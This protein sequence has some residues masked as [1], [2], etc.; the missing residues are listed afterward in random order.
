M[1]RLKELAGFKTDLD[2]LSHED[3]ILARWGETRES[4]PLPEESSAPSAAA[5]PARSPAATAKPQPKAAAG[6]SARPSASAAPKTTPKPAPKE[7]PEEGMPPDFETLLSQMP[8]AADETMAELATARSQAP[9]EGEGIEELG[10]LD[11]ESLLGE[12]LQPPAAEA[13][14]G[15]LVD[16]G[17]KK[18]K[19]LPGFEAEEEPAG[20]AELGGFELGALDL[21]GEEEAHEAPAGNAAFGGLD[22]IEGAGLADGLA[23][24]G[25]LD[26]PS[27]GEV[28]GRE[29]AEPPLSFSLDELAS[30]EAEALP[31]E[32]A[33]LVDEDKAGGAEAFS[34]A[35]FGD[36]E[37]GTPAG[38]N[39]PAEASGG[40]SEES[41][42]IPDFGGESFELPGE[43][44]PEA[45]S[46]EELPGEGLQ[47]EPGSEA[48]EAPGEFSIPDLGEFSLGEEES[49]AS[50]ATGGSA[51]TEAPAEDFGFSIPDEGGFS[52]P[53]G[54]E[55]TAAEAGIG[56]DAFDSFSL[57][58]G[59]FDSAV[60]GGTDL[61]SQLAALGKGETQEA[62]TFSLDKDW[63]AGFE[64]PGEEAPAP[65]KTAAARTGAGGGKA[66]GGQ[67]PR[68]SKEE[69][70]R[71][72]SLSEDQVDRLQDRLLSFPLNLRLAV[73]DAIANELGTEAQR[74]KLVWMLVERK[75]F[76]EVATLVS[77]IVK[78]RVTVP[79]GYEKSTGADFVAEKG[80]FK[81][82][83]VHTV[84]PILRT[85][86]LALV[87]LGLLVFLGYKF[88]YRPLEADALYRSGYSHIGQDRYREAE[89]EFARAG[90]IQEYVSWYYR[91]AE[92]YAGKRQYLLAEKKYSDLLA[93][94]PDELKGA[95]A[96]AVLEKD[97]LK[98]KEG[99]DILKKRVLDS[100]YHDKDA[101][102][103]LGDIYL[104]WAGEDA[105]RYEDARMSYAT[106]I[107][108]YGMEDLYLSRMLL[109]F[110]RTDKL[111][112]VL[113]LK[114]HF[115]ADEKK[116]SLDAPA[117]AELGGYLFDKGMLEEVRTV[118]LAAVK[119]DGLN[120]EAHYNLARYFH[121]AESPQDER[122]ALDNAIASLKALTL[123]S[124][125]REAMLIDSLLRRG[126]LELS[127]RAYIAAEGDYSAAATEY[128]K[129]L[130]LGR[131][132]KSADFAAAY[133]G[134][135]EV[136]Y[137][138]R[139]DLA[140]ALT[141]F[142]RAAA[143]GY[144]KPGLRYQ[145]GYILYGQG[146]SK[147]AL[148]QLYTAGKGG[149]SPYLDFAFGDA[150]YARQD[151]QAAAA[152]Y[153]AVIKSMD[154]ALADLALPSPSEKASHA[155]IMELLM[156][157]QNNLGACL[158]KTGNRMGNA[159]LRAEAIAAFTESARLYDSLV[160]DQAQL[161][162]TSGENLGLANMNLL[163]S[164]TRNAEPRLY[165]R[166]ERG[167]A[168]PRQ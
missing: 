16:L 168:F 61:D 151:Y 81:Y 19:P 66:G 93:L 65:K 130:V 122:A 82:A 68:E 87:A 152:N 134:L 46:S 142:E 17:G 77:R 51:S 67:A 75:P 54:D 114:T 133:A 96:W 3:E 162:R 112:E 102:L 52:M 4:P 105:A 158:Y 90:K 89:D 153:R 164:A 129:A 85:A 60:F 26:F 34:L 138:Q 21:G 104:E 167:M 128:D 83:F 23:E 109:Y 115:L 9:D 116:I 143:D 127:E 79:T 159:R 80:S 24:L 63:G 166:L 106:L 154:K 131:V 155:E 41:F 95:L 1:P 13:A 11:L 110:I 107:Q 36:L 137:W 94:H 163:L 48:G 117:L 124:A 58:G 44:L 99:A 92:A 84:L 97:Q 35:D 49:P 47:S 20:T 70:A 108:N 121:K 119:K 136:A 32:G 140:A 10:D 15:G 5:A 62:E 71:E 72:V 157:A 42:A 22:G 123:V 146:R 147:D 120:P 100:H 118:L 31:E 6:P 150:L 165:D 132:R 91:Y 74:A 7:E 144:D 30:T 50:S 56:G 8:L 33:A 38:E 103:L 98:Y 39:A 40:I 101:L 55:G 78:R 12:P 2:A 27:P 57:D 135:G 160:R 28:A 88:I 145:R 37:S 64:M 53:A 25:S 125:K 45:A 18:A 43:S 29:G 148:E 111:K 139:G 113:P 14:G 149:A 86:A 76:D 161:L 126:D 141:W 69:K 156:E 73:E 59:S